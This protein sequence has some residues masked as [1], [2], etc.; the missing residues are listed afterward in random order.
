MRYC[1]FPMFRKRFPLVAC[2]LLVACQNKPPSPPPQGP[3]LK[4]LIG[5]TTIVAP[6]ARPIP[7]SIVVIAGSKIRAVGTRKDVQ[8]PPASDRTDL[9]G[10][11]LVPAKGS[12]IA[13]NETANIVILH[14][15]PDAAD[16]PTP[17]QPGA[18]IVA[19]EWRIT[20]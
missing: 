20:H 4:V 11:W 5:A 13:V 15:S 8:M 9:T 14:H 17:G 3:R 7:D 18:E 2:L 12:R 19:G 10:A 16:A 1:G 6:G